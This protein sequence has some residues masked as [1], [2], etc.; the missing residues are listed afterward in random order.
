MNK[1]YDTLFKK[2]YNKLKMVNRFY[3]KMN[4]S[5]NIE[6]KHKDALAKAL[7]NCKVNE[8]T[9]SYDVLN[10]IYQNTIEAIEIFYECT[11]IKFKKE[12]KLDNSIQHYYRHL[13][14]INQCFEQLPGLLAC[15]TS[16]FI[17]ELPDT[18]KYLNNSRVTSKNILGEIYI[19]VE[20]ANFIEYFLITNG[21]IDEIKK[22]IKMDYY[23]NY[24]FLQ[25][26]KYTSVEY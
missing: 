11:C 3:N 24:L 15:S 12:Y 14:D 17:T 9:L 26:A 25:N 16:S 7:T 13:I 8:F 18:E 4:K 5:I 10:M 1:E 23:N 2:G 21:N 6:D 20:T 22:Y 19:L